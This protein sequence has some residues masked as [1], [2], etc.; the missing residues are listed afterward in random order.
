MNLLDHS[1]VPSDPEGR[2][3]ERGAVRGQQSHGSRRVQ[4]REEKHIGS[5]MWG[6]WIRKLFPGK[7]K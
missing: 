6:E 7:H 5:L 4:N 3:P 1:L 2:M